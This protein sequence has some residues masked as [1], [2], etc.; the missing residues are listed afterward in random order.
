[1]HRERRPSR[2]ERRRSGHPTLL[3]TLVRFIVTAGVLTGVFTGIRLMLEASRRDDEVIRQGQA[4]Q[5][6][7]HAALLDRLV[8]IRHKAQNASQSWGHPTGGGGGGG[9][10]SIP[11]LPLAGRDILMKP[12][13]PTSNDMLVFMQV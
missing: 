5:Q 2:R 8:Q 9:G 1:M 11:I 10:A 12:W 6:Q 4:Q 3:A 7:R 13:H